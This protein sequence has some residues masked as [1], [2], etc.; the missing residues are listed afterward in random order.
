MV[1]W[2]LASGLFSLW[3]ICSF[4]PLLHLV[5]LHDMC[6]EEI[7]QAPRFNILPFKL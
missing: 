3:N 2:L 6:G 5:S 4:H 7:Q 1:G